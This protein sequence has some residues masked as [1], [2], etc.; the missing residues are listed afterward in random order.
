MWVLLLVVLLA[1]GGMVRVL[2]VSV[3]VI[4]IVCLWRLYCG[5]G[6][7]LLESTGGGRALQELRDVMGEHLGVEGVRGGERG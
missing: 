5:G 4:C 7:L 1:I 6:L 3:T 2:V